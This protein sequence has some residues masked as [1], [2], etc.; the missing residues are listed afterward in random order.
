MAIRRTVNKGY[1]FDSLLRQIAETADF[2][3]GK[4]S[5]D[6]RGDGEGRGERREQG[7]VGGRE[8]A[9]RQR[10]EEKETSWALERLSLDTRRSAATSSQW[11]NNALVSSAASFA[12]FASFRLASPRLTSLGLAARTLPGSLQ[13][14]PQQR[15]LRVFF[16]E[17]TSS[18]RRKLLVAISTNPSLVYYIIYVYTILR[19]LNPRF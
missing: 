4:G 10:G 18:F 6:R 2:K 8:G 12:S 13:Q 9:G 17:P 7:E 16:N 19:I 1:P 11:P 3:S 5:E 15:L 14:Q